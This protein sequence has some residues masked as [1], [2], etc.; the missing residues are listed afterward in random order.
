MKILRYVLGGAG[1]W[2]C[3]GCLAPMLREQTLCYGGSFYGP[4]CY[5]SAVAHGYA[6]GNASSW[7]AKKPYR[8]HP[9]GSVQP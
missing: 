1:G 5:D 8:A 7:H 2:F 9:I 4:C 6:Q 3:A